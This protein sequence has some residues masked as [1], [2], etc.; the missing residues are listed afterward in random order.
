MKQFL[1]LSILFLLPTYGFGHAHLKTADPAKDSVLHTPPHNVVLTF[2]ED[3]ELPMCK[4]EVTNQKTHDVV[5]TGSVANSDH[6][7]NTLEVDLKTLAQETATYE[8]SWKAVGTDSHLMKGS[9]N[10]S[11]VPERK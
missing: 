1:L 6:K 8:V 2:S 4:I 5:S 7:K 9:Y 10:F 3:L 11:V